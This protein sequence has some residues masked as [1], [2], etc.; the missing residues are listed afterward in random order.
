MMTALLL[1]AH[2][3]GVFSSRRIA[4]G[5]EERVDF[6]HSVRCFRATQS[7]R[8]SGASF[9]ASPRASRLS[10]RRSAAFSHRKCSSGM[11]WKAKRQRKPS[12]RSRGFQLG[13]FEHERRRTSKRRPWSRW[14]HLPS[15]VTQPFRRWI[16][17]LPGQSR[18]LPQAILVVAD[19]REGSGSDSQGAG[20]WNQPASF[21]AGRPA[22]PRKRVIIRAD[23]QRRIVVVIGVGLD[24]ALELVFDTEPEVHVG[25][26]MS[27]RTGSRSRGAWCGGG[28]GAGHP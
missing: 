27:I 6:I 24:R 19:R 20:R 18:R 5:G 13:P 14:N 23:R 22:A 3:Q 15:P 9:G 12:A 7:S 4:R 11:S 25:P 28:A 26:P 1:Y 8:S 17:A 10:S 21:L 2:A 16:R